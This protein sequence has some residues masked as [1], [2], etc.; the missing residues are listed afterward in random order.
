[1]AWI[2]PPKEPTPVA[3]PQSGNWMD[4]HP[5][6]YFW[7]DDVKEKVVDRI[8]RQFGIE[9]ITIN[10]YV[11]HP[12]GWAARLGYDTPRR[13]L[14]VWGPGGRGDPINR[15]L[16]DRIVR[17]V[18]NLPGAPYINW[19]IWEGRIWVISRGTWIPWDDDGTGMHFDHPHF[20][21]MREDFNGTL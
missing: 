8:F 2:G 19:C 14:D 3:R 1:M 9:R 15:N 13:S 5:T 16:G 21:Y 12:E 17:F 4:R 20:T 6:R 7:H 11:D 18:F 10:T